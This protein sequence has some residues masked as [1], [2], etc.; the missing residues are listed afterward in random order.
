VWDVSCY[1]LIEN[2]QPAVIGSHPDIMAMAMNMSQDLDF[3]SI[4]E[5]LMTL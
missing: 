5:F 1:N 2:K 3:V 4:T